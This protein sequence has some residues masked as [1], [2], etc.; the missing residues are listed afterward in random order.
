L[1]SLS[2]SEVTIKGANRRKFEDMLVSNIR[3]SLKGLGEF[4]AHRPAGRILIR[5]EAT[6]EKAFATALEKTFG[7]DLISFCESSK[8]QMADIEKAVSAHLPQLKGRAIKVEAKR[9]DKSFPLTSPEVNKAIGAALVRG[10]CSVD[11]DDPQTTVYIDILPGEA[12]LSFG[13]LKGPGGL[14]VGSSGNVLSLLSGGID[15]P[16]S[17]WMMMKRG[18]SA[19]LLH[20]HQSRNTQ[21]VMESKIGR[22]A[23]KLREYS[24]KKIRLYL[25]PYDE[26]YKATLGIDERRELVLFRRFLFRLSSALAENRGYQGMVTGDSIGQVASQTL[27]NIFATDEASS[28][29]VFRP[30]C[31]MNKQEIVDISERIGT[32]A[33]SIEPYKDCCS[34]ISSSSP[35]TSVPRETARKIE[36]SMGM[37]GIVERTLKNIETFDV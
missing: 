12:L 3:S 33:A 13:R 24:P 22:L 17:T 36:D 4:E 8:P 6:D 37:Q 29:P 35:S 27:A 28:L 14:P 5:S 15:S 9:S 26:F 32:F 1:I 21:E 18:C 25:A 19:D 31:G 11:L 34:L 16:V 30:L 10:G 7:I 20:V 2:C 23:K